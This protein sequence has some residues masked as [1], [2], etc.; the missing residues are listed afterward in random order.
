MAN[1]K[2]LQL[3]KSKSISGNPIS[4]SIN[5]SSPKKVTRQTSKLSKLR[6]GLKGQVLVY[7]EKVFLEPAF[8]QQNVSKNLLL[9]LSGGLDSTVLL[10]ILASLRDELQFSLSAMHVHH[11]LSPNADVWVDFCQKICKKLNVPLIISH[12]QIPTDNALGIEAA[13]RKLRYEALFQPELNSNYVCFAHHQNDQAET[14]LL[15]LARGAGIKGLSAMAA[16]DHQRRLLRPLLDFSRAELEAYA[17]KHGLIWV[18]DESNQN[19]AFDR[20]FF[21]NEILPELHERHPAIVQTLSRSASHIA[22]ASMLLDDLAVIDAE[23]YIHDKKL[24][25][26]ALHI[27]SASRARNLLRWWLA[28]LQQPMPSSEQLGQML[29]QLGNAKSDAQVEIVLASKPHQL[30]TVQR[31]KNEAYLITEPKL[32][33]QHSNILWQGE[34]ELILPDNSRLIFSEKLGAGIALKRL[35]TTKLRVSYRQGGE[36]FRPDNNRP[37]RSLK[38][39]LQ[40]T[41]MPPWQRAWLPLVYMDEKLALVPGLGIDSTMQAQ[42]DEM[43]WVVEWLRD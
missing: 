4:S 21:R 1:S 11:G 39:L 27:L 43:G 26:S 25:I 38:H 14:L 36:R 29:S 19:N 31:Y 30:V 24:N 3:N 34:A 8:L 22:E 40:E 7:F 2:N 13:A 15:Q 37:T 12:I 9:A 23:A 33:P 42:S 20:N 41:N 6:L 17:A 5:Q 28:S 32:K 16:V 10:H 35:D 18:E